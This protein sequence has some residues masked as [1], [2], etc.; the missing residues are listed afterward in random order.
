MINASA[1]Q[2]KAEAWSRTPE[3]QRRMKEVIDRYRKE[4]RTTTAAGSRLDSR[5]MLIEAA[6][7]M[8]LI[9]RR[10]A[11]EANLPSSVM[12]HFDSM[13][14]GNPI[15]LSDGTYMLG[16]YFTDDLHRDSLENDYTNYEG[17]DNI[18]ALFNNGAHAEDYVYGWW[19][20][21]SPSGEA[22]AHSMTGTED[23][24]WVRSKKDREGLYFIQQ[25][26]A[27]FN[28]NYGSQYNVTATAGS[29]YT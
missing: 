2:R 9:L 7:K 21:P 15:A 8:M 28:G 17:V 27:D 10:A 14:Y 5:A 3:G 11:M 25:A 4:G 19:N 12:K 16:I 18:I 23:Y 13:T 24:A 22:I 20:G 1:L 6:D 29:D 26:V